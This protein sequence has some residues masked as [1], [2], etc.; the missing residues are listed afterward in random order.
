MKSFEEKIAETVNEKLNDGTVEKLVEQYMEKGVSDAL[1][2]V[3][4]WSGEGRKLIEKKLNET[5]V[6][7]IEHHD[8]N[9]YLTKLDSV[10]TEIVNA[11][12]LA[13]NKKILENFKGLMKEPEIKEIR[14]SEIFKRY[15]GHVAKNV[16]TYALKACCDDGEPYY[17]HVTAGMEVEHEDKSKGWF[18][19]SYEHCT[20]KFTCDEDVDLNC[21]VKL[22]KGT[23]EKN[24]SFRGDT[25]FIDINSLRNLSDFEVF[26]MTLKRGFVDITMDGESD[27]DDDIEPE[28]KPEWSLG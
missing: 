12:V 2:E 28:K 16:D 18:I 1:K 9:Q 10:L 23:D 4:S 7:V 5:V 26:L 17:E 8:F 21:Q 25:D 15:C 24:W 20:V 22:Y 19:S 3:F 11:T 13:D 27:C 6:P 14:L